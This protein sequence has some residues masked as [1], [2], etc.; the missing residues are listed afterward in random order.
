MAYLITTTE[1][2]RVETEKQAKEL[3]ESSKRDKN[4]RLDKYSCTYKEK[5]AKGDVVDAWWR[6]TLT[7]VFQDEKEPDTEFSVKYNYDFEEETEGDEEND[8]STSYNFE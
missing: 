6:V 5:K 7:K 3:I 4:Y 8:E 2:Y 1:M